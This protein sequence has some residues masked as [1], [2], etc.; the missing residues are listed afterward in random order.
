MNPEVTTTR[1]S[2]KGQVVIPE[3]VRRRLR[4]EP[5]ARFV[6]VADGDVIV[7]KVIEAPEMAVF[8]SLVRR[9]RQQARSTGMTKRAVS[10]AIAV[11]RGRK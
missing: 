4:L 6:I 9:A 8:D 11:V 1:M 2:S 5:G 7:L 10:E 3:E